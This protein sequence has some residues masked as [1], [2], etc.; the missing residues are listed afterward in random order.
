MA[1]KTK[2]S[3]TL[4]DGTV[5]TRTTARAYTTVLAVAWDNAVELKHA[6]DRLAVIEGYVADGNPHYSQADLDKLQAEVEAM[7][8][9]GV[10]W[11][12]YSWHGSETLARKAME[13]LQRRSFARI[14]ELRLVPVNFQEA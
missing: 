3:A 1:K 14:S 9:D 11:G 12:D 4:P 5:A 2:L 10:T 8:T 7:P 13:M 6:Q